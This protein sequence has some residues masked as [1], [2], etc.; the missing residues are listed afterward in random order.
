MPNFTYGKYNKSH[1]IP[2]NLVLQH[3]ILTRLCNMRKK[4]YFLLEKTLKTF[5]VF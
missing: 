4:E 1:R 5:L 3:S 2:L